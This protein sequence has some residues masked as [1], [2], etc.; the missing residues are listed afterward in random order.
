MRNDPLTHLPG[1]R[2]GVR[3]SLRIVGPDGP[4]DRL[5]LILALSDD[6]LTVEDRRGVRHTIPRDRVRLARLV[7]TVA[8]GR[9][10]RHAPPELLTALAHDPVLGPPAES[11]CWIARLCDL[12]DH[13]DDSEVT[14]LPGTPDTGTTAARNSSRGLVNGEW[15]AFRLADGGDLEALAAWA[16]RRNARNVVATSPLADARLEALGLARLAP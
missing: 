8:R 16:A 13:L 15:A 9:N 2:P 14:P 12:V 5:G 10:P 7:P 6:E 4:T 1:V 3:I 11:P